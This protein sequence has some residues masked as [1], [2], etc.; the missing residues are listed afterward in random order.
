MEIVTFV[1]QGNVPVTIMHL[2]G[3]LDGQNYQE[4]I[5]K[6]T[7]LYNAGA[8]NILL[9]L[10]DLTYIS[11]AGIVAL[12]MIALL[13]RGETLPDPERGWNTL[14]SVD[15]SRENGIQEHLKLLNPRPDVS[16]VLDLVGFTAFLQS[17]EDKAI[18]IQSF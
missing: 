11:S 6:A 18:A 16:H 8:K 5:A 17:F 15:R 14:K 13:L 7:E 9:D 10:S 1:E 2:D 3:R 4:L 12:H